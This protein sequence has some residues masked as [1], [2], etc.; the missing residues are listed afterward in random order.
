MSSQDITLEASL[1]TAGFLNV[2]RC[3][4]WYQQRC[5][6]SSCIACKPMWFH[7]SWRTAS[8]ETVGSRFLL[9]C[10]VP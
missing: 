2:S 4:R 6:T 1:G 8:V 10:G 7:L 5:G 3:G 9:A